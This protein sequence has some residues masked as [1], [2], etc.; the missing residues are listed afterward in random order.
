MFE[1]YLEFAKSFGD[2]E[3]VNLIEQAEEKES[4]DLIP[5]IR[6]GLIELLKKEL[7][8]RA[9]K[10]AKCL[11]LIDKI[12]DVARDVYS[13]RFED[14]DSLLK[15]LLDKGIL[16]KRVRS[17]GMNDVAKELLEDLSDK[18][19]HELAREYYSKFDDFTSRARL[20]YHTFKAGRLD[21]ALKG[22]I[23]LSNRMLGRHEC[24]EILVE[25]GERLVKYYEGDERCKILG[26]LGNLYLILKKYEEAE[27]NYKSVLDYYLRQEDPKYRRFVA[28]VLHNLGKLYASWGDLNKAENMLVQSLRVKLEDEEGVSELLRD[29]ADVYMAKGELEKAEKCLHDALREELSKKNDDKVAELLNNLGYLYSRKGDLEKA[30]KY[31]K[32]ALR[33]YST[34]DDPKSKM[35]MSAVLSNLSSLYMN[36]GNLDGAKEILEVLKRKSYDVPPDV[37][38]TFYMN[39]AKVFEKSGEK[40]RASELYLKAGA[41]GFLVFRN[42]GINAVN[43]MHCL[44]KAGRLGKGELK[45]DA[46]VMKAVIMRMYYGVKSSPPEVEEYGWRGKVLMDAWR[47]KRVEI[48]LEDEVDMAVYVLAND[49]LIHE[50]VLEGEASDGQHY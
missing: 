11:S 45:G 47:G 4:I 31:Y 29:L 26:T 49:L 27:A 9:F 2:E 13:K 19:E 22:F 42:Y 36:S 17:Y 6:E 39:L 14:Y 34:L 23:D 32:E 40:E 20:I 46:K 35:N 12:D 18:E 37:R 15:E 33:V 5:K 50:R 28:G 44:D 24:I 1:R 10:L 7:S 43:F 38:A 25:V 48:R 41:L 16:R 3:L 21:E 30:E 8:D